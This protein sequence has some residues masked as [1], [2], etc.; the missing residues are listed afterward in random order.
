MRRSL[1]LLGPEQTL[2]AKT[3][4]LTFP[5][6]GDVAGFRRALAALARRA[7]RAVERGARLLALSDRGADRGRAALPVLLAVAAVHQE[8]VRRGKRPRAS[9][10]VETGEARDDHHLATLLAF[11]AD[12]V[13]PYLALEVIRAADAENP[14]AGEAARATRSAVL[15]ARWSAGS[16]KILSKMGI[17]TLRSYQGAPCSR[18]SASPESS[19]ALLSRRRLADR[20]HRPRGDRAKRCSAP[21]AAYG[22]EPRAVL[23]E[24][25]FHRFRRG[26]E[27]HAFS[28]E[29][30][31]TLHAAVGS[32]R[33]LDYEAYASLVRRGRDPLAVRD[34]L[35]FAR[36]S[37][38]FRSR[39]SSRSKRSLPLHDGGDVD[40]RPEPEAHETLAIAMNRIGARSNSGEGGADPDRFWRV[41][42]AGTRPTTGSSRS[43]R[44]ASA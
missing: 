8:L 14:G 4:R 10:V 33:P 12:A 9:L 13:N 23:E 21:C 22:E 26:G 17:S 6:K 31:R 1:A 5:A 44:R 18:R 19:S 30:V 43:P 15:S 42:P 35:E 3:L 28:P 24:G 7:S 27:A 2:K 25:G 41:C 40:R 34:L 20:R 32:G 37:A 29:V 16:P 39:R 36:R 38:R 11:G